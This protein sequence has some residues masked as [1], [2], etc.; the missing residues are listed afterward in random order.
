M[1]DLRI[2]AGFFTISVGHQDNA[3]AVWCRLE[4][5]SEG[6]L[7]E[8]FRDGSHDRQIHAADQFC[9]FSGQRIEGAVA[10]DDCTVGAVWFVAVLRQSLAGAGEKPIRAWSRA[11]GRAGLICHIAA[12]SGG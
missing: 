3:A 10:Q 11:S 4:P 5:G 1:S 2:N 9:M 6:N 7:V 12:P 8:L